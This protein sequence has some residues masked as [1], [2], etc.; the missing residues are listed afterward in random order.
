V[1]NI[2][3]MFS[4]NTVLHAGTFKPAKVDW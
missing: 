4:K 1:A 3:N 2:A